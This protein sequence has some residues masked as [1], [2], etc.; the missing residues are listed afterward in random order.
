MVE[1][2][3]LMWCRYA[4][5][6]RCQVKLAEALNVSQGTMTEF[7][8]TI[9]LLKEYNVISIRIDKSVTVRKNRASEFPLFSSF[10]D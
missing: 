8:E 10:L 4:E 2:L 6:E 7:S 5:S 1:S 3:L 9:A